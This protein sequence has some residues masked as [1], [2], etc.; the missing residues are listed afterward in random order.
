MSQYSHLPIYNSTIN[1]LK[2][3]YQRIPK[4]SKQYKYLLGGKLIEYNTKIISLIFE[5]S[6]SRNKEERMAF[7]DEIAKNIDLLL[8][9][10]RI[11]NGGNGVRY[12][13]FFNNIML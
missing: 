4:F 10:I 9:H 7:V 13:L 5:I 2:D 12:L 6:N 8:I 3:L 1:C 11:C